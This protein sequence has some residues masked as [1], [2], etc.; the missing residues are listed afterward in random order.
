MLTLADLLKARF[1]SVRQ[2]LRKAL[3]RLQ[4]ED[5]DWAPKEGMP[6]IRGL[7]LE[8]ANKEVEVL[9]WVATGVWPDDYDGA[10]GENAS[11]ALIH[12]RLEEIRAETLLLIDSLGEAGLRR[13][14]SPPERW[15]EALRLPE[16]PFD[17]ILRN[18][19]AHE[20]Y[21]TG[22]IVTYL[23]IRGDNPEAW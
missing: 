11:L 6:A 21:H 7:L 18:I 8:I 2:D 1:A 20:W 22:Q 9:G 15:W 12:S 13:P 10:F 3:D 4:E 17:E 16:C 19:A 23:W 14:I 5:L